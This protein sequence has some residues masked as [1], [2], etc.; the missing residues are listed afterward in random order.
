V[1]PLDPD[2]SP[3]LQRLPTHLLQAGDAL[4]AGRHVDL[5]ARTPRRDA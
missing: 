5:L 3:T 1:L 2:R 4:F